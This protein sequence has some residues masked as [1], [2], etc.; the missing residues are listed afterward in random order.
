[1]VLRKSF[2]SASNRPGARLRFE[3]QLWTATFLIVI[4]F[5]FLMKVSADFS[6]GAV[7]LFYVLGF[8]VLLLWQT[9]GRRLVRAGYSS[10]ALAA[11]RV[12]L[13]GTAEKIE[14][15]RAKHRPTDF[16]LIISDIVSSV[17]LD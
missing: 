3:F 8:P 17:I 4:A 5:A 12:L 16:G 7:I 1:M 14:E 10:G 13:L 2:P 6:R 15:F 9:T 11:H